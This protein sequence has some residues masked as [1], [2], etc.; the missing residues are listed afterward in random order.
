MSA[1]FVVIIPARYAS[2]RLPGKPL[3]KI[4]SKTLIQH[5]YEAA[6]KSRANNVYVATDDER[7]VKVVTGFNGNA[8]LTSP[9]L[10]SGTDRIHEAATLLNFSDKQLIVNVQGDEYGLDP[11]YINNAAESLATNHESSMATLCQNIYSADE[12]KNEN[13][14]KVVTD[15]SGNA[16][17]FSRSVIPWDNIDNI[18]LLTNDEVLGYKH[19]GVYAYRT[20]FLKIFTCLNT[21]KIERKES[22]EQLRALYYGHKIFV[23]LVDKNNGIEIN[24]KS[25]LEKARKFYEKSA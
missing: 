18:N 4:G 1:D 13:I 12:L 25:D 10:V 7:I 6:Q 23:K 9:G 15:H 21:P 19:I 11:N 2:K 22:L 16:L 20:N 17:Y 5:V 24:T 3:L 14:V 8:L